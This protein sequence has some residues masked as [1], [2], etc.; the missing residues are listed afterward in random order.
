MDVESKERK[1]VPASVYEELE[2]NSFKD[3][4]FSDPLSDETRK[5]RRNLLLAAFVTLVLAALNLQVTGVMGL[6]TAVGGLKN[7]VLQGLCFGVVVYQLAAFV[8]HAYVDINGWKFELE[9]A[10]VQ[11]Y[12]ELVQ[13]L[14]NEQ[15]AAREQVSNAMYR[16]QNPNFDREMRAEV[17]LTKDVRTARQQLEQIAE[18]QRMLLDEVKPL[19][20][21]WQESVRR[22]SVL[23]PRLF[24]RF[25]QLVVLDVLAPLLLS[26]LAVVRTLPHVKVAMAA[27]V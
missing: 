6:T 7:D 18:H 24:A 26:A 21:G 23:R 8:L 19:L 27:L 22:A 5:V 4:V 13:L 12:L 17:E 25:F 1:L 9:R 16:L 2:A 3:V 10:K 11:P 14:R 15:S 20:V